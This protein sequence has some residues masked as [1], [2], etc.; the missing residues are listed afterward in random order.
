MRVTSTDETA[1]IPVVPAPRNPHDDEGAWRP[2]P[3]DLP[4][5]PEPL[6]AGWLTVASWAVPMVVTAGLLLVG[7]TGS[8][9]GEDELATWGLVS[10]PWSDFWQVLRNTD[11]SIGP[12]YV[13]LRGWVEMAGTGDVA[14]RLP[15]V[16]FAAG[17][18]ALVAAAGTR[19]GGRRVG[20][21]AGLLFAAVPTVS[22]YG[23]E[24]R[25][26]A[27]TVFAA[28]LATFLLLRLLDQPRFGRHAAYAGAIALLGLAHV[29]ALLIVPA[30]ALVVWRQR[31]GRR[32]VVAWLGAVVVGA[33]P[34]LPVLYLGT[35]QTQTQVGWIPPLS[36]DRLAETPSALF[37]GPAIAGA[38]I[39]LAL[40]ALSMR[41]PVRVATAWAVVPAFGLLAASVVVPLWVP[42]Y[43]FFV[44]PAWVLL[45]AF[46]LRQLTILRGLVAVVLIGLLGVTVQ[47]QVR[48]PGGHGLASRDVDKVLRANA[49]PGDAIVFGPFAGGD[50][51]TARDAVLRYVPAERRPDDVLMRDPPRT[52]GRLGA[53]ECL[54]RDL[55][56]CFGRQERV[57]VVRKGT[58]DDPLREI[59]P[60]KDQLLK[61]GYV[62]SRTWRLTGL[63]MALLIRKPAI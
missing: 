37:G 48:E 51:R 40:A 22:R 13:L 47:V 20:F 39:A 21:T 56:V 12:Y 15:S 6:E 62:V 18:A 27:L 2:D 8:G 16:L 34:V 46:A 49:E 57:W 55:P 10:A 52:G 11:A 31:E 14:L 7:L 26:Y 58:M 25:P 38:V 5:P 9:L 53:Q 28:A 36:G 61:E 29:V 30:H 24:A 41:E 59:G 1:L 63:V 54:D 60:A 4:A 43:L 17:A 3:S 45:A 19:V 32:T 44:V 50:Q 33:A 42:R 23:Q 35:L